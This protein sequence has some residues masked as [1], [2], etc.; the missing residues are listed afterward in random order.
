MQMGFD[1]YVSIYYVESSML[2]TVGNTDRGKLIVS[3]L[4][5]RSSRIT[6]NISE[7]A[8]T[9]EGYSLVLEPLADRLHTECCEG[10]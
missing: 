4:I 10:G 8:E 9:L 3:V 1:K 7:V 5:S 2:L 6:L